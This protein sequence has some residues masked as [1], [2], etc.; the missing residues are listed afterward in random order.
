MKWKKEGQMTMEKTNLWKH[1][2]L[3]F[4]KA[5][6]QQP[7]RLDEVKDSYDPGPLHIS[8]GYFDSLQVYPLH[9]EA[10]SAWLSNLYAHDV[11]LS[12]SL[13]SDFF[14][15]PVHCIAGD[16]EP[17]VFTQFMELPSPYLFVT[18]FQG[19]ARE[20][21]P[22][23]EDWEQ[24]VGDYLT[25][26]LGPPLAQERNQVSWVL[27]HSIT[28]SDLII[29][30]KSDSI[31]AI[32]NAIQQV[33]YAPMAGDL[34]S[35]PTIRCDSILGDERAPRIVSEELPQVT[36]RYLVRNA[37]AAYN[38]FAVA[39]S[40][41]DLP[42]LTIGIEDLTYAT[43]GWTTNRLQEVLARRLTDQDYMDR[44]RD[45]F[46]EC[47]TH[48]GDKLMG[49][50]EKS[51]RSVL[52]NSQCV[53][54]MQ[55]FQNL[56]IRLKADRL[57]DDI[58][59][60]WLKAA[61]ELYNALSTLSQ[62]TMADGFCFL[63]LDA[64]AMFLEK[65]SQIDRCLDDPQILQI[66]RFLRGWGNLMEQVLRTDGK[67]SQQPGFSP[68]SLCDIPSNL[69]E[70]YAAFTTQAGKVMQLSAGDR[71]RFS[72]LL[73][74]KLC[75]R[76][77]V[78]S[79]FSQRPPC[80]RLLF[81]DIPISVLYDPFTALCH[82]THEIGHFA[83]DGWRLRPLRAKQYFSICAQEL[84]GEFLFRNSETV[85]AIR[86]AL[87]QP[88]SIPSLYLE[89]LPVEMRK[90]LISLLEDQETLA[91]W[92]SKEY[93][94][95]T[96]NERVNQLQSNLQ[97]EAMK[98][99]LRLR[100]NEPLGP[101]FLIMKD[102]EFLFREC[103]ADITVIF[104]LD[105]TPHEYLELS[106]QEWK[107]YHRTYKEKGETYFLNVERWATV[108]FALFPT[109]MIPFVPVMADFLEDIYQCVNFLYIHSPFSDEE[110]DMLQARY[111]KPE[112]MQF[113]CHYLRMCFVDMEGTQGRQR[114][115]LDKLQTAFRTLVQGND[116]SVPS[117]RDI[118]SQYRQALLD[119]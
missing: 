115:Q 34:H 61:S 118:V 56:R 100:P 83:G 15:H 24:M 58:D 67:F 84:A 48:L 20:G 47:E 92:F 110:V 79:V 16:S 17:E 27:Y 35:I 62:N 43:N 1:L 114:E 38:F 54:L 33:Y 46:A 103:Y 108:L 66:Q 95:N 23:V 53:A 22:P 77:K 65:M 41:D 119:T 86:Q 96:L 40:P 50:G 10:D 9:I 30:W 90:Q 71:E 73:V 4:G 18:L 99:A 7:K 31:L 42:K 116:I 82:L 70:F 75:R 32:M 59:G 13:N 8:L 87:P 12:A 80:D 97:I 14:F 11:E 49:G 69:L 52:L 112:S 98:S 57:V 91:S 36:I 117:C 107:L 72:L 19:R 25:N 26:S 68:P 21:H 104:T 101:F 88:S 76:I 45:A 106:V 44:F 6:T 94:M 111:H 105:L 64:A 55:R 28:L 3:R 89:A 29:L 37:Q 81:V 113:L 109:N 2:V 78:E 39:G 5:L 51:V 85:D 102:F 63:I 60:P 74:P 93:Y